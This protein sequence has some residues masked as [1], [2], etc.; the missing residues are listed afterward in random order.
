MNRIFTIHMNQ[1]L[2]YNMSIFSTILTPTLLQ[3]DSKFVADESTTE[4][5]FVFKFSF[6]LIAFGMDRDSYN[7]P[8]SILLSASKAVHVVCE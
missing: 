7:L 3:A 1:F 8:A 4:S 6:K 5:N 2:L